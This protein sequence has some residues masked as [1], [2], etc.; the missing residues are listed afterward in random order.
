MGSS[1]TD[2]PPI[3]ACIFD[4]DGLLID[5]EDAYTAVTNTI[6]RENNRPD[7]PWKIKAQLQGR[8]GPEAGRIFHEWAKLPISYEKFVA[9][10]TELQA[11]A[12]R[13]CK[14]LPGVEDL[15]RKL[16]NA[17]PK[18]HMALATSSI[19]KNFEIKTGSM[20]E[21]FSVFA[22]DQIVTGDDDRV[23]KGRG[24]PLPDI[25]LVALQ[26]INEHIRR[27]SPE[28]SEVQPEECIVFEDSVPGV[29]AG[30]RAGM[31]V[32]WCP[33]PGLLNEYQGREKEVLAGK[34]G[35]HK[36]EEIERHGTSTI[37]GSPGHVGEID[38]GWA[39]ML[40]TL[41]EFRYERYK[42]EV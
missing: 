24:K 32:V 14:P 28:E 20:K 26:T 8:P 16:Q 27:T 11:E 33:N 41:E 12:F 38:D 36:E 29:E 17:R 13:H 35:E 30:R 9:R 10:N 37:K 40:Q 39:E 31:R 5:S 22:E 2:F 4:V 42:I 1:K 6:L 25:Y 23:P 34:T 15:L 18:V 3:R 19:G 21:M 7:L